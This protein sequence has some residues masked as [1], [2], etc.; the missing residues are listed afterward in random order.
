MRK[1]PFVTVDVFASRALEGNQLAVFTDA[2]GLSEVEMPYHRA[3]LFVPLWRLSS[4]YVDPKF[5]SGL[6][7]LVIERI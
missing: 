5:P 3:V 7:S 6:L 2:R 1:F 4:S